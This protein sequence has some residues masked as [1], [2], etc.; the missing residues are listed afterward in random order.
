MSEQILE[1]DIAESSLK[2]VTVSS[3]ADPDFAAIEV[4]ID[5][6]IERTIVPALKT[7]G[8]S[9]VVTCPLNKVIHW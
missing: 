7:A 5:D 8:D 1:L 4:I 6:K 2:K 3:L 9:G